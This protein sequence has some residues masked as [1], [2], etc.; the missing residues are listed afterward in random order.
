M[1][2]RKSRA[3]RTA[4]VVADRHA[5]ADPGPRRATINDIARLA[6][7]SKKTVS[8]VI[9]RSPLVTE[10]T[11]ARVAE[12]IAA[13]GYE[14]DPQARGLAFRRSFL[15]GLIY[16]N[17]NAQF[18]VTMQ[19]G[20]LDGVRGSGFELV[21]HPCNRRS[22][23]LVQDVQAFVQRQK[24]FGVVLLP[25]ISENDQLT[26]MLEEAGCRYV[27][28]ASAVLD[29]P[30]RLVVS[31]D[32]VGTAE[33]ARHLAKLGHKRIGLIEGP[34]GY[35]SRQ[36]RRE[37]FEE[38]L[39]EFGLKL[40]AD[41]KVDGLY[42]YDSGLEGARKLLALKKRPTAIFACNDEMAAGAYQVAREIGLSIPDDLSIVGFDD[43]PVSSRLWPPLTTIRWPI[44]EM[45]RAAAAKLLAGE[46]GDE[47][48]EARLIVRG[49]TAAPAKV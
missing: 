10:E 2:T 19:Q 18:V 33:A 12:V 38:G 42:T 7:V 40:P 6:K 4:D 21:V 3:A 26:R 47:V 14:P 17:P 9:N 5:E 44:V 20:L 34:I 11:R 31:N 24:L 27:R 15:I 39:A 25:P 49:S 1:A 22:P 13:H 46:G 23:T 35:R 41:A 45:G 43:T 16:D 30:E 37:G 32:R 29:V 48:L 36:E 8:R 28:V